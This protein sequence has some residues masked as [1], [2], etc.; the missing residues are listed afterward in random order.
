MSERALISVFTCTVFLPELA[1]F[2]L[3]FHFESFDWF[4]LNFCCVT[5]NIGLL[6]LWFLLFLSTR[7]LLL[8]ITALFEVLH[9]CW[10]LKV[11]DL[12]FPL[13]GFL[14]RIEI[15]LE[16]V[17][18][19]QLLHLC[20]LLHL[21]SL[22]HLWPKSRLEI[23]SLWIKIERLCSYILCWSCHLG[24]RTC[25]WMNIEVRLSLRVDLRLVHW[26]LWCERRYL[27]VKPDP[28]VLIFL[29][30]VTWVIV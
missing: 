3:K 6:Q 14:F 21:S 25:I 4:G 13:L 16:I 22:W 24:F 12:L 10:S 28:F 17:F 9:R 26:D 29:F 23:C 15:F 2:G 5:L 7:L 18:L 20:V 30:E 11:I 8:Q 19:V 1:D 27:W